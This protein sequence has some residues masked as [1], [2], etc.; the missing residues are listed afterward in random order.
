MADPPNP[1][2]KSDM[3]RALNAIHFLS[4]LEVSSTSGS[5]RAR[6]KGDNVDGATISSNDSP[7][8]SRSLDGKS[9]DYMYIIVALQKIDNEVIDA[10]DR[11]LKDGRRYARW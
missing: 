8:T 1:L 5:V 2:S 6:H 9:V 7:S 3:D 11:A 10:A 4:S